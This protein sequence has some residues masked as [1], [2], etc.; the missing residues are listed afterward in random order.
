[1]DR[2]SQ[3]SHTYTEDKGAVL[4]TTEAFRE[5]KV[6]S[7]IENV[8]LA[9]GVECEARTFPQNPG[10]VVVF[11]RG[12]CSIE[13]AKIM[14]SIA[15]IRRIVRSLV[16]LLSWGLYDV[17]RFEDIVVIVIEDFLPKLWRDNYENSRVAVRCRF[18]GIRGESRAEK[19]IGYYICERLCRSCRIDLERPNVLVLI[20]QVCELC[21]AYVGYP[22]KSILMYRPYVV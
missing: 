1:M 5:K 16:P 6:A 14:M 11:S 21:G 12:T 18:R 15:H 3:Y 22:D 10:V 17:K 7:E 2:E 19:I 8:L 9:R 4:V 13:L 20:E